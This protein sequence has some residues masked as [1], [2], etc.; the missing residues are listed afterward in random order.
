MFPYKLAVCLASLRTNEVGCERFFST[1]GY[2][3]DPRR[4]SLKVRNYEAITML[5]RNMQ[6]IS[7]DEEW[8]VNQY[9]QH[10]QAKDWDEDATSADIL[11]FDLE[12]EIQAHSM[13]VRVDQL[14]WE[15]DSQEEAGEQIVQ[16]MDSFSDSTSNGEGEENQSNKE[17]HTND[18][19]TQ[20]ETDSDSFSLA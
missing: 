8:V 19:Q 20:I 1:A 18:T 12:R 14:Q 17:V 3:S 7:I 2:V 13:G 16:M 10:E 5:K 11:M 9:L 15:N 4:T 6:Y